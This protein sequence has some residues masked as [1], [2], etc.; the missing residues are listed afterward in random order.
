MSTINV[1]IEADALLRFVRFYENVPRK[2][3]ANISKALNHVGD[4]V[5]TKIS[6]GLDD[7][8]PGLGAPS[9][10]VVTWTPSTPAKLLYQIIVHGAVYEDLMASRQ[11]PERGFP[12][13]RRRFDEDLVSV[14]TRH[15]DRVCAICEDIA[16]NG[17]YTPDEARR[18]IHHGAG[19]GMNGCRCE[20][21][22]YISTGRLP[23]QMV[24]ITPA[25]GEPGL[26][27]SGTLIKQDMTV[28]VKDLAKRVLDEMKLL[29]RTEAGK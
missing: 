15:D 9:S 20:L 1:Q 14:Q 25:T 10:R 22:P 4:D 11:L 19:I 3:P 21:V 2:I 26:W 8:S 12:G 17:P 27:V 6:I 28:T 13:Q 16:A 7:E 23:V 29:I 5:R 18:N 24:T